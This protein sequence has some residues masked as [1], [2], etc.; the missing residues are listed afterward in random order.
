[1]RFLST[2]VFTALA[3]LGIA[4]MR[5][6]I[7][8]WC[9]GWQITAGVSSLAL[10][11]LLVIREVNRE[12]IRENRTRHDQV[13]ADR[14]LGE[15]GESID[16]MRSEHVRLLQDVMIEAREN[17]TFLEQ[18]RENLHAEYERPRIVEIRE[19]TDLGP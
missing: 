9:L 10:V 19:S 12:P 2:R 18:F 6:W 14:R 16:T 13:Q 1:M 3:L 15:L 7:E 11:R 5:P 17:R 4:L 8:A